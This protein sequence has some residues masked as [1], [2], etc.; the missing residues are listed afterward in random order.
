MKRTITLPLVMLLL[1]FTGIRCQKDLAVAAY[2]PHS[3][4]DEQAIK[5][6]TTGRLSELRTEGIRPEKTYLGCSGNFSVVWIVKTEKRSYAFKLSPGG[7]ESWGAM[8]ADGDIIYRRY[9]G[10]TPLLSWSNLDIAAAGAQ[11]T[12]NGTFTVSTSVSDCPGGRFTLRIKDKRKADVE[13]LFTTD[14]FDNKELTL[15]GTGS[16]GLNGRYGESGYSGS[17]SDQNCSPGQHGHHGQNGNSG[18][19]GQTFT[20]YAKM[21]NLPGLNRTVMAYQ[22]YNEASGVRN[23]LCLNPANSKFTIDVRGG[24][25]GAGGRGGDGGNGPCAYKDGEIISRCEGGRGGDGG[26][27]GNGGDGGTIRQF[28]DTGIPKGTPLF[29]VLNAGGYGGNGGDGGSGG[30]NGVE[31]SGNKFNGYARQG[32][33]G[34]SGQNGRTGPTPFRQDV[35]LPDSLFRF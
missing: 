20:V 3:H 25:G 26:S 29:A 19:H 13:G 15:V 35:A 16:P 24:N 23:Y 8:Q 14:L 28:I 17:S 18:E 30:K 9:T 5:I 4:A 33:N 32:R 31:R 11:L 2:G 1:A 27:G 21:V 10:N 22:F 7:N 34:Y 12:G 6:F